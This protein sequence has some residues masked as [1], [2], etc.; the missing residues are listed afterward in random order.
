MVP[1]RGQHLPRTAIFVETVVWRQHTIHKRGMSSNVSAMIMPPAGGA[2]TQPLQSASRPFR[3]AQTC[4]ACADACLSEDS[5]AD[6]RYCIRTDLDC[7]DICAATGTV[8]TCL[9]GSN[10]ATVRHCSRPAAPPALNAADCESTPT[11]TSTAVSR[12][13]LPPL[14]EGCHCWSRCEPQSRHHAC[15][16]RFHLRRHHPFRPHAPGSVTISGRR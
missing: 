9:T 8:L 12:G 4:T 14:R 11:T 10:T 13:G 7:A 16:R 1:E 5:V 6:L 15:R 2:S 3:C